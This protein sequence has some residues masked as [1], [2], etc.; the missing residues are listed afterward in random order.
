ME[1][2]GNEELTEDEVIQQ[3]AAKRQK[4]MQDL[5][6]KGI[7]GINNSVQSENNNDPESNIQEHS[8][9][10]N[11]L[12][13][14]DNN[15]LSGP[16]QDMQASDSDSDSDDMFDNEEA[17]VEVKN[18][19]PNSG[20]HLQLHESMLDNWDDVEGYYRIIPG[21]LIDDRYQVMSTL[22]RG[23]FAA[24]VRAIDLSNNGSGETQVGDNG[25]ATT[26]SAGGRKDRSTATAKNG[27]TGKNKVETNLVAI[28]IIRNNETM[29]KAGLKEVEMLEKLN[30]RDP[31]H[32][33][34]VVRLLRSFE[35]KNHLCLVFENLNSNLREILKKF[36]RD[37]GLNIQAIRQYSKQMI[38][39]LDLLRECEIIHADIKPD[40]ILVDDSK[41][42]VKIADLGSALEYNT[43]MEVTSYLVSRFY[44]APELLLGLDYDFAIDMWSLGCSLYELYTGKILFPGQTNNQMLKLMMELKGK[45]NHRM[46]RKGKFSLSKDYFNGDMDFI[47]HETDK[48]TGEPVGKVIKDVGPKESLKLKLRGMET[49]GTEEYVLLE[50]FVDLLDRMLALDP[51]KRIKPQEALTHPFLDGF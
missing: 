14:T 10:N 42:V 24:V 9:D 39:G 2:R 30:A 32:V 34:N 31:K 37:I 19:N 22:G 40:N 21:E 36:G 29:T 17:D 48:V 8:T 20:K 35:H 25:G 44:R 5:K 16:Q 49:P 4:L 23:V 12:A 28:K 46:I 15:V 38:Q 26:A 50:Q 6:L 45:V 43:D 1:D 7:V 27:S 18:S 33:R 51:S 41:T 11:V 13:Q 47:S 3:R